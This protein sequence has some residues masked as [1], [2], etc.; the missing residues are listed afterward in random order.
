MREGDKR[1]EVTDMR[2]KVCCAQL[3]GRADRDLIYL[4]ILDTWVHPPENLLCRLGEARPQD[5][6]DTSPELPLTLPIS[7][8]S[9]WPLI[10][11]TFSSISQDHPRRRIPHS[12]EKSYL[13]ASTPCN[14]LVVEIGGHGK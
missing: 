5:N 6:T 9:K 11:L 13:G 7:L 4:R 2:V 14:F 10:L 3:R 8:Q 1:L 12:T